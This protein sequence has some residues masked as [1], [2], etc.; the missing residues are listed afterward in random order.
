MATRKKAVPKPRVRRA[1]P[2]TWKLQLYVA[3]QTAAGSRAI[4]NLTLICDQHLKGRYL[5]EVIDLL[6]HPE[7]ARG[8]QI[9]AIPTLVIKLPKMVRTIVG[10]LSDTDRAIIGIALQP[11]PE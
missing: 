8:A 7:L 4:A 3:G 9:V 2:Q 6:E 1:A 11:V 5:I 10:D